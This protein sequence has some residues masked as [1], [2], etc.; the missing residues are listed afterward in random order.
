MVPP[1]FLP[2][3]AASMGAAATLLGLLFVAVSIAPEATVRSGAPVERRMVADSIFT[4]MINAFFASMV[5]ATPDLN[6]GHGALLLSSLSLG[7]TLYVGWR[8][9]PRPF[10]VAAL[11]RRLGLALVGLAIYGLQFAN[12]IE[13]V[14]APTQSS[15]TVG[16]I[17]VL[18]AIYGFAIARSWELLGARH[19]LLTSRLSPLFELDGHEGEAA[20]GRT[21]PSGAAAEADAADTESTQNP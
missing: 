12:A 21:P 8:L 6:L 4:A 16:Q 7:H 1:A 18:F 10:T 11:A 3:F 14:R 15:V 5:G 19:G 2:F 17:Y 9:W 20:P 13:L